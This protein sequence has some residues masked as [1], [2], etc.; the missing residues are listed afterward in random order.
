MIAL[1]SADEGS[2]PLWFLSPAMVRGEGDSVCV[3]MLAT[4]WAYSGGTVMPTAYPEINHRD[5]FPQP[6]WLAEAL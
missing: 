2:K 6:S 5:G 3:W 1:K 4:S